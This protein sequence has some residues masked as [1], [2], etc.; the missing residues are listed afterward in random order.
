MT[1]LFDCVGSSRNCKG[2]AILGACYFYLVYSIIYVFSTVEADYRKESPS[3]TF[4]SA[5]WAVLEL[6]YGSPRWVW[7]A[8]RLGRFGSRHQQLSVSVKVKFRFICSHRAEFYLLKMY[9]P[10]H[11]LK[12]L[13]H[14]YSHVLCK[15]LGSGFRVARAPQPAKKI[16]ENMVS[17]RCIGFRDGILISIANLNLSYENNAACI[18]Q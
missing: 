11:F 16:W 15:S 4:F 17:S 10:A 8:I 6:D 5:L 7:K 1:V 18:R 14:L 13:W 2:D 9:V 3:S 12:L